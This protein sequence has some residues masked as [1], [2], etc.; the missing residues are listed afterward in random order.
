MGKNWDQGSRQQSQHHI[1]E[2]AATGVPSGFPQ[3]WMKGTVMGLTT[4]DTRPWGL[5][6][7]LILP[8]IQMFRPRTRSTTLAAN[9]WTPGIGQPKCGDART[10]N[11]P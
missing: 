1:Q 8:L 2:L 10:A 9:R 7:L 4:A 3:S 6:G 5:L 11:S